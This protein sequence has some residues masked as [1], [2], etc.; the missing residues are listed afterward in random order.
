MARTDEGVKLLKEKAIELEKLKNVVAQLAEENEFDMPG[1]GW[2]SENYG[3]D[4]YTDWN[5]SSCYGEDAGE[6]FGVNSDGKIW[7]PSSC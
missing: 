3:D 5:N 4:V 1:I 2:Q 6:A 7:Y